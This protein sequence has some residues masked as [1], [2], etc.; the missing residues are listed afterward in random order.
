MDLFQKCDEFT[1]V[2]QAIELGLYPYFHMLTSGQ[3][4]E[5]MMEGRRTLMFGSNNYLG[6]TSDPRVKEAAI[7]AV[8]NMDQAVQARVFSTALW[9]SC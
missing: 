6:L 3:D 4:T 9:I 7:K 1:R 2:D 5:V 8:E